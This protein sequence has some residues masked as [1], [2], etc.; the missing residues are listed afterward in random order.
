MLSSA[1]K[2]DKAHAG[3]QSHTHIYTNN[4]EYDEKETRGKEKRKLQWSI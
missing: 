2:R 1:L 3:I 4:V